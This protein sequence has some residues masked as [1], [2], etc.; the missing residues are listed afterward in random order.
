MFITLLLFMII[1]TRNIRRLG[2]RCKR[3]KVRNVVRKYKCDF[4]ILCE[5][6][7]NSFSS[8]LLRS[9]GGGRLT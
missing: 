4:L 3:R 6:K 7:L 5:T 1:F 9:I 2:S 8:S